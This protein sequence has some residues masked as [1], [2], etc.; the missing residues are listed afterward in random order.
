[1]QKFVFTVTRQYS[2]GPKHLHLLVSNCCLTI[3]SMWMYSDT[4]E[5]VPDALQDIIL[6]P[7]WSNSLISLLVKKTLKQ[8]QGSIYDT[9]MSQFCR[10]HGVRDR[11]KAK[12]RRNLPRGMPGSKSPPQGVYH[13]TLIISTLQCTLML[14]LT[15]FMH[16][17]RTFLL[18]LHTLPNDYRM[19]HR[20][21]CR[22]RT[23]NAAVTV[24]SL[25]IGCTVTSLVG[26]FLNFWNVGKNDC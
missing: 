18:T 7:A 13:C 21:N 16:H 8:R 11:Y 10:D 24:C 2:A 9:K 5:R 3:N 23:T 6:R 15:T 12:D 17:L 1:M 20:A 4:E 14:S 25:P 26:H 19:R 22:W